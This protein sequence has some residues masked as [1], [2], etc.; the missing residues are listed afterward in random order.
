[1]LE[2]E[3][4]GKESCWRRALRIG[5]A[6]DENCQLVVI[7]HAATP[8]TIRALVNF[9]AAGMQSEYA[10]SCQT[11]HAHNSMRFSLRCR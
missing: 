6:N 3:G 8:A 9:F 11:Q 2:A 5:D 4:G 1:M 10:K 7:C